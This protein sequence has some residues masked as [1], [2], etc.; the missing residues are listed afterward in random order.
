MSVVFC[1]APIS[2]HYVT[3]IHFSFCLKCNMTK[4]KHVDGSDPDHRQCSVASPSSYTDSRTQQGFL[5]MHEYNE[6]DI[7]VLVSLSY[8]MCVRYSE[9]GPDARSSRD[10]RR[11][12]GKESLDFKVLNM[13]KIDPRLQLSLAMRQGEW[14]CSAWV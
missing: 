8:L 2:S 3:S 1:K 5:F 12:G 11:W 14:G 4:K 7:V 13:L 6:E 9:L 10:S